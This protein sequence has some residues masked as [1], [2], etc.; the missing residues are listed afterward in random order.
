MAFPSFSN[1]H[2]FTNTYRWLALIRIWSP[3]LAPRHGKSRFDLNT[4][5]VMCSFLSSDGKHIVLLA[6]SGVDDVM[7][8]ITSDKDGN[9]V[10][11][12]RRSSLSSGNIL[13]TRLRFEMTVP[14]S[15]YLQ[16]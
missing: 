10:L 5:A 16:S 14:R 7:T 9:V 12:V 11:R 3:W 13:L 15:R 1:L 4:E 2:I 6:I 8:L